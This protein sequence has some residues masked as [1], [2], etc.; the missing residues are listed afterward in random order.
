MESDANHWRGADLYGYGPIW[1]PPINNLLIIEPHIIEIPNQEPTTEDLHDAFVFM[2]NQINNNPE[3]Y[4]VIDNYT[5]SYN[6]DDLYDDSDSDSELDDDPELIN[7]LNTSFYET[8]PNEVTRVSPEFMGYLEKELK[9]L[10]METP[11]RIRERNAECCSVCYD[12]FEENPTCMTLPCP[13]TIMAHPECVKKWLTEEKNICPCC[14]F[15][16]E[17]GPNAIYD[18]IAEKVI[19]VLKGTGSDF[20]ELSE[21]LIIA[22]DEHRF[23]LELTL[24]IFSDS[25]CIKDLFLVAGYE[26]I[27]QV[28]IHLPDNEIT[29]TK[30]RLMQKAFIKARTD[31]IQKKEES[32]TKVNKIAGLLRELTLG[33]PE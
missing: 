29:K 13:C 20:E 11:T 19:T 2:N 32:I 26:D 31:V 6:M 5:V 1:P 24:P 33:S 21:C 4:G 17:E 16:I 23:L 28:Y 12:T 9:F 30:N 22:L 27:D 18:G 14:R 15:V 7:T 10:V 8:Q 25:Q 3:V